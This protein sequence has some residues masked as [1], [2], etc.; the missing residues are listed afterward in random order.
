MDWGRLAAGVGTL[1][2]SEAAGYDNFKNWMFGGNATKGMQTQPQTADYQRGYLKNFA[3]QPAPTMDTSQSNDARA[4][5]GT[6]AGMLFKT[7]SGQ[8]PGPGELAVQR[9][10]NQAQAQN[11]S[12]AQMSRGADAALAARNAGRARVDIGV[13]GAGQRGIAQMGDVNNAQNQLSGLLGMQ[14]QQDIGVAGANQQAQLAQQQQQLQAM[15]QMLGVDV[16]T[17][18]QDLARRGLAQQDKGMFPSL[19]QIGGQIGAA[20]ATGGFGGDV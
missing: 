10:I 1:G 12:A 5:Q 4:Q 9:G 6:L 16:A 7:A 17:L 14:R 15:A 18:Q 11:T 2:L 3:N 20:A 13:N 8:T 19:L